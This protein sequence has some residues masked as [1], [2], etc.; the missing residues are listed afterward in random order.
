MKVLHITENSD[1]YEEVILLANK[2][3][4]LNSLAVIVKDNK[5]LLTGGFLINDTP[6]IRK[7]L[8]SIDKSKQYEFVKNFKTNPFVK[9]YYTDYEM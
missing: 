2:Y 6:E 8:D 1:G 3:S 4:R 5:T 7:V 9:F